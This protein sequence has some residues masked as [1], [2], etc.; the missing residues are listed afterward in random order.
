MHGL[1]FDWLTYIVADAVVKTFIQLFLCASVCFREWSDIVL[2]IYGF[3][4]FGLENG[5]EQLCINY[6]NE[7]QQQLFVQQVIE[8]EVA[9]Y[10][11]EGIANPAVA[12]GQNLK[13]PLQSAQ[14]DSKLQERSHRSDPNISFKANLQRSLLSSLPDTS[15]LLRELQEG[16]FRRLDDSCRLL[17]QGQA[18]DDIHFWKDL[19][20]YCASLKEHSQHLA[21][22]HNSQKA[23][24]EI[25]TPRDHRILFCL[26][27]T[28]GMQA[29][30]AAASGRLLQ[31]LEQAD[32]NLIGLVGAQQLAAVGAGGKL[33]GTLS[34]A[35]KVQER[36]FAVKHF[37]GTVLYG[38]DGWLDL[39][40]DRCRPGTF[41]CGVSLVCFKASAYGEAAALM[42]D[43][44]KF[45]ETPGDLCRLITAIQRLRLRV[46]VRIIV[47]VHPKLLWL[48]RR[49]F[50]MRKIK[51]EA[52]TAALRVMLL[53]KHILIPL[54][55]RAKR[56]L[57]IRRGLGSLER[58]MSHH[59][60]RIW[61]TFKAA[62]AKPEELT[63]VPSALRAQQSKQNSTS[64]EMLHGSEVDVCSDDAQ[65]EAPTAQSQP[66]THAHPWNTRL[67][68][69]TTGGLQGSAQRHCVAAHVGSNLY[70]M[71]ASEL[72]SEEEFQPFIGVSEEK[73]P[74]KS[75]QSL[76][77]EPL[78]E[79]HHAKRYQKFDAQLH[80]N[81]AER[82]DHHSCTTVMV[83]QS[84]LVCI[85]KHPCHTGLLLAADSAA[86]L[87]QL[88]AS[89]CRCESLTMTNA[90]L[91]DSAP[92]TSTASGE[93]STSL[94]ALDSRARLLAKA[95]SRCSASDKKHTSK[96]SAM[97]CCNV[98]A[99]NGNQDFPLVA[100]LEGHMLEAESPL[101]SHTTHKTLPPETWLP[102]DLFDEIIH[103]PQ[104]QLSH[105]RHPRPPTVRPLS[106]SFASPITADYAIIVCLVQGKSSK[107]NNNN[108]SSSGIGSLTLVL[109]DL[110]RREPAGWIPLSFASHDLS[111]CA[112]RNS[113]YLQQLSQTAFPGSNTNAGKIKNAAAELRAAR[114][115]LLTARTRSTMLSTIRLQ[116]LWGNVWAV[117]GPS[118]LAI[119]SINLRYLQHPPEELEAQSGIR[120]P[121]LRLLWNL[122]S[123][124]RV[125]GM[126]LEVAEEWFTGC[127][128]TRLAPAALS[129][130]SGTD[131]IIQALQLMPFGEVT[132]ALEAKMQ[133]LLLLSTADDSL[134]LLQWSEGSCG[135]A[136]GS[137]NLV[138]LDQIRLPF[139]VLQFMRQ[140]PGRGTTWPCSEPSPGENEG[141]LLRSFP[142]EAS[143]L[144]GTVSEN[145]T[146][147]DHPERIA[148]NVDS[149]SSTTGGTT[150]TCDSE[151]GYTKSH[152]CSNIRFRLGGMRSLRRDFRS[153][154]I[155][156]VDKRSG[157]ILR[158]LDQDNLR[159]SHD[160]AESGSEFLAVAPLPSLP[161]VL[162]SVVSNHVV[163][164]SN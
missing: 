70:C 51:Q 13:S 77:Q 159:S 57:S 142:W 145:G 139:P 100:R 112:R 24:Q 40:N 28:N 140:R 56:R 17:A 96:C 162:V 11:R 136:S 27:G 130:V 89:G 125:S 41:I 124:P 14:P 152:G 131:P 38:T 6:A 85:A 53:K 10:I 30:E 44:A 12:A 37:A 86:N 60:A 69:F 80:T 84:S 81:H 121:P 25:L 59:S 155:A 137:G 79:R 141:R 83:S 120:D 128:Y 108:S 1:P 22:K 151:Q 161:G 102:R 5:L 63:R 64:G 23:D 71:D 75:L 32:L 7:K 157:R 106:V 73:Q 129:S 107:N 43:P 33:A 2:D 45:F 21:D 88:A 160:G 156:L 143:S 54:Q 62:V 153:Y 103:T 144:L 93:P 91:R 114:N 113:A 39:N 147:G 115:P 133:R 110:L 132:R 109:V 8:E 150:D 164:H 16:V 47:H 163:R 35:G 116:P 78:A 123:V 97:P 117:T 119:F 105:T 127:T 72:F 61:Q 148:E 101:L 29:A 52:A 134:V 67:I 126:S 31:H 20:A 95:A 4:S 3:E 58:F 42:T 34:T 66:Q 15:A 111:I 9:L 122:A 82:G 46:A 68:H 76:P 149:D 19:F 48:Q 90:L 146:A 74:N 55:K 135:F 158:D 65:K 26:K 98:P 138:L 104:D 87:V 18:R 92:T 118:L 154:E 50:L 49:A 94:P 99:Y 36:V